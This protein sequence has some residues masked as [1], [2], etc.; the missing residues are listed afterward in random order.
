MDTTDIRSLIAIF[1]EENLTAL[2]VRT[3]DV[4]IEI[5]RQVAPIAAAPLPYVAGEKGA[6]NPATAAAATATPSSE[7]ILV[8]SPTVGMFYVAPSPDE[9]PYVLPGQEVFAG[10]TLCI[11]ETMKMMNEVCAPVGGTIVEV[12]AANDT[13]VEYDQPLFRIEGSEG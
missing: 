12:L 7:G 11:V 9:A 2:R 1:N 10:Q 5:E 3:G 4:D 8:R 13:H 6:D